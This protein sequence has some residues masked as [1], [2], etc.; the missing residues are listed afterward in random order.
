MGATKIINVLKD[1]K[2]EELLDIV[3]KSEASEVI[4]VLPKKS[5]AFKTEDHFEK[6][7]NEASSNNKSVSFLCSNPEVN[8]FARKYGFDVLTTKKTPT[9]EGEE[10]KEEE[11]TVIEDEPPFGT[12]LDDS[13]NP[14]Y[15][16]EEEKVGEQVAS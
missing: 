13:G 2:F 7:G 12:N 5:R 9:E 10:Y 1:D 16:D 8:E 3:K 4:F 11:E 6:L 14:V 15:D